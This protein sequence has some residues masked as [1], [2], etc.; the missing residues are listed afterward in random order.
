MADS[1]ISDEAEKRLERGWKCIIENKEYMDMAQCER[2]PGL[3]F[4]MFLRPGAA[5][6]NCEYYFVEKGGGM[7]D[8][9]VAGIPDNFK[10]T[11]LSKYDPE[12]MY[13]VSVC[14]DDP[15]LGLDKVLNIGMFER[16]TNREIEN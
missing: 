7:W 6:H 5:D 1:K 4:F 8:F 12:R 14:I 13:L 10:T 9:I 11:V 15:E 3:N 2:V 16:G